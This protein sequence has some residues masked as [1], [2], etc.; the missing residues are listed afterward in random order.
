MS[1][2]SGFQAASFYDPDSGTVVQINAED[3]SGEA[4]FSKEEVEP[5]QKDPTGGWPYVGHECTLEVPTYAF[6]GFDQLKTWAESGARISAV[7][8]GAQQNVQWYERDRVRV[9]QEPAVGA[10]GQ[11]QRYVIRMTRVSPH[12]AIYQRVN[13]LS[14]NPW[15]RDRDGDSVVDG[16]NVTDADPALSGTK[17]ALNEN[18]N[19]TGVFA[20][21]PGE[22]IFPIEGVRLTMSITFPFSN[23][24]IGELSTRLH[25]FDGTSLDTITD[26]A[27]QERAKQSLETSSQAWEIRPRVKA[28]YDSTYDQLH[29]SYPS[30]RVDGI[31]EHVSY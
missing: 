7:V 14:F 24:A 6:E 15:G 2:I 25:A 17:Q 12:P 9:T 19:G 23:R 22:V 3:L 29:L 5:D 27:G 11:T 8:A 4:E 28:L 1:V 13:L 10:L 20:T 31:G 18:G 30:L 16:Y 26:P 21:D